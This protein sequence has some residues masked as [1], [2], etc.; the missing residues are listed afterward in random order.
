MMTSEKSTLMQI[1]LVQSASGMGKSLLGMALGRALGSS[2][3]D[4][5]R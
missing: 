3:S 4:A 1:L 5:V 2:I